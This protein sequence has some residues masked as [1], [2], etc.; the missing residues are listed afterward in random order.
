MQGNFTHAT[1]V[2]ADAEIRWIVFLLSRLR[3]SFEDFFGLAN[4]IDEMV[5]D[6][7]IG[8]TVDVDEKLLAVLCNV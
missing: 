1:S 7:V 4:D 6:V 2:T 3:F 5:N 8:S